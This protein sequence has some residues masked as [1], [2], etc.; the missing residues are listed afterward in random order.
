MDTK[1]FILT[2]HYLEYEQK[3]LQQKQIYDALR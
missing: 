2:S 1:G 3:M